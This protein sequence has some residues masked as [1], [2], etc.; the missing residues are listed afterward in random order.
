[1]VVRCDDGVSHGQFVGVLDEVKSLGAVQ[2]AVV[3]S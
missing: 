3:G 2:I 1:V